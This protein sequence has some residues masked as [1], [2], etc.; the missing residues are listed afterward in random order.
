MIK[1]QSGLPFYK[2]PAFLLFLVL[3]AFLIKGVLFSA[4]L[5]FLQGFDEDKHF[6]EVQF[7]AEPK[8]K[9]WPITNTGKP[10]QGTNYNKL[11][12]FNI[13]EEEINTA[14]ITRFSSLRMH[15]LNSQ[16]FSDDQYGEREKEILE[17]PWKKYID[18]YPPVLTGHGTL[19]YTL[20]SPVSKFFWEKDIFIRIA[21]LRIFSLIFGLATI[22]FFYLTA[23]KI[24][25]SEKIS[26]LLSAILAFQPLF[27]QT[28]A[29]INT[30]NL[31][32]LTFTIFIFGGVSMLKDGLN[33]KNSSFILIG[34]IAG[35]FTKGPSLVMIPVFLLFFLYA[36]YKKFNHKKKYFIISGIFFII[37]VVVFL[38]FS[39]YTIRSVVFT[40]D[41][42]KFQSVSQSFKKYID[43][44]FSDFKEY[45]ISYWGNFGL[46][47]APISPDLIYLIWAI[48]G[49]SFL[50][51]L[52]YLF[53]K[54]PPSFF[55]PDKKIILFLLS[56]TIA[57]QFGIRFADWR[58]FNIYGKIVLKNPGRYFLPTI[59]CHIL[60]VA[61]GYL[62][63][64]RKEKSYENFLKL[65][66]V[67]M[68]SLLFYS[69]FNI[70]IPRYY[71]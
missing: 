26:A 9:T 23:K 19:Y 53:K 41:S 17:M 5:P 68:V 45:E 65:L 42:Q 25:F 27:T 1:I 44:S 48:E 20:T 63:I 4:L 52:Y 33:W 70:I 11:E 24:G 28:S 15:E 7:N 61:I 39:P 59:A 36:L 62:V 69:V 37:S 22:V 12:K 40:N 3:L 34:I 57:L 54:Y 6:A 60:L 51:L 66:L 64:W 43:K 29:T 10:I 50:G 49:I 47:N 38:Y 18:K 8:E 13:S 16:I 21:A 55:Q 32:T 30:D 31:L 14:D 46:L 56:L 2:K 35:I 58:I 67:L 71:L